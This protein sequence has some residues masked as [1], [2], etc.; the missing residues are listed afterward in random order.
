VRV[1]D[2]LNTESQ[3]C[4]CK[5]ETCDK[6]YDRHGCNVTIN[7]AVIIFGY[8]NQVRRSSLYDK[9][10]HIGILLRILRPVVS[11]PV[12][13]DEFCKYSAATRAIA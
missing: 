6:C 5:Y 2:T 3:S 7:L 11:P 4:N 13:G 8:Y 12:S 1:V 9:A 10:G